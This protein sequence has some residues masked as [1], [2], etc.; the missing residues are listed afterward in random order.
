MEKLDG[1]IATTET[2]KIGTGHDAWIEM[3][4]NHF[5]QVVLEAHTGQEHEGMAQSWSC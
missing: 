4:G 1:E 2:G 5:F 3:T